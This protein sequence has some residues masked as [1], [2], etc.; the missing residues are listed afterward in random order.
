M[1]ETHIASL[2][3]LFYG[4]HAVSLMYLLWHAQY[5]RTYASSL[6]CCRDPAPI[7]SLILS[8]QK[9]ISLF[10]R[11]QSHFFYSSSLSL[12]HFRCLFFDQ[13]QSK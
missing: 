7:I 10:V 6:L 5:D 2:P 11:I 13:H 3:A 9:L 8:S 12:Q 1:Q 4:Y